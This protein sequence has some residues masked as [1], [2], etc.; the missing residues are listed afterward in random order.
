MIVESNTIVH[1]QTCSE[2]FLF[3]DSYLYYALLKIKPYT[4][5]CYAGV[6]F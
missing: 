4:G 3:P 6:C 1:D 5:E 2:K